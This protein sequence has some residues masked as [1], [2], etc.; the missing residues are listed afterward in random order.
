MII[1]KGAT[2]PR[3]ITQRRTWAVVAALTV[4]ALT[5]SACGG[6]SKSG[7]SQ[8]SAAGLPATVNLVSIRD[9]SG[10]IANF[11]AAAENGTKVAVEEIN[12]TKFLGETKLVVDYR[13]TTG[14]AQTAASLTSQ[15]I[16]DKKYSV[17]LGPVSSDQ[18]VAVA[19]IAQR[20][21]VP[22]VFT[23]A[24][25]NGVVIGEYTFRATP[26]QSTIFA[27]TTEYL[28]SKGVTKLA[29]LYTA[30]NPTN[31]QL[32]TNTIPSLAA[33][34]GY[35][36]VSSSSVTTSTL[37][38]SAPITKALESGADGVALI[39]NG[40]QFAPA[41]KL[42]RQNN[43]QGTIVAGSAAGNGVL[44]PI[45]ADGA[46]V[47]YTSAFNPQQ[48]SDSVKHFVS[49]YQAMFSTTP[50]NLAAEAYDATWMVARALKQSNSADPVAVQ[51]GL[52]AV[53]KAGF[54]GALGKI[55]FDGND[56]RTEGV[57][58]EW[59][60]TKEVLLSGTS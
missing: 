27:R 12:S 58:T 55:T 41:V 59:D 7:L 9:E 21:Q 3:N 16:A 24:G 10:P 18:A 38:F 1:R 53:A 8:S 28:T 22:V 25:S 46:G 35:Q 45:G 15:A 4:G 39:L 60:G 26:P 57:L 52:T 48:T 49:L 34:Y 36:V 5:L 51:A 56:E 13:D 31:E 32:A 19:P 17:I 43:F 42:L 29:V 20:A 6:D 2:M 44:A 33:Q 50:S 23:Q 40:P 11:G 47:V 30:G 54:T 37:D 14:V